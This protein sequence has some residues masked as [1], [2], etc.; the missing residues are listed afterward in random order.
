M[1]CNVKSHA[2]MIREWQK[3]SVFREKYDALES[4]FLLLDELLRV[5]KEGELIQVDIEAE[6]RH[7]KLIFR[8]VL[9]ERD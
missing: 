6:R 4:E 2:E 5:R 8:Q 1:W 7:P 9:N 3:D